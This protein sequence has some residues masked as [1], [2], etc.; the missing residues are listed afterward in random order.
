VF[1]NELSMHYQAH[2]HGRQAELPPLSVQYADYAIWQREYLNGEVLDQQLSYWTTQLAGMPEALELP[3]DR[4]RGTEQ[5]HR[6]AQQV[7]AL[8][9]TLAEELRAFS[10]R[11]GV[12]LYMTVLAAFDVLLHYYT[13]RNDIVAGTNVSNRGR[14]ETDQLI[15]F[16]VNQLPMRVDLSGD[17]EFR[18]LLSR[19]RGV[20]IDAYAHQEVPFDRLVEALKLERKLSHAPLFQVKIDLLNAPA[21]DLGELD[22]SIT[23]LITDNGGSHLDLIFSLVNTETELYGW[24]L[25]NTDLFDSSTVTRMFTRFE[26][27]LTHIVNQPD[28]RLSTIVAS[29]R[30]AEQQEAQSKAAELRKSRVEK[31]KKLRRNGRSK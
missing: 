6:G 1:L 12:T 5:T 8:S 9:S 22:L 18:E 7:V 16:F 11:E 23:P 10:K 19:V 20:T 13:G 14:L 2:R 25:Y 29:L 31:L 15:G 21:V 24:L 30:D 4:P 26:S 17:P 27:I 3:F 28:A